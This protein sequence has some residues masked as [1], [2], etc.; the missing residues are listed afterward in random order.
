[1]SARTALRDAPPLEECGDL[2]IDDDASPTD[3]ETDS[4][5]FESG[6]QLLLVEDEAID[7]LQIRRLLQKTGMPSTLDE[8]ELVETAREAIAH[9]DFDCVLLDHNL[10]DGQ[11]TAVLELIKAIQADRA[12]AVVFVTGQR[13]QELAFHLLQSGAV[14][15][16]AKDGLTPAALKHAVEVALL[17]RKSQPR[18][19]SLPA[20]DPLTELPGLQPYEEALEGVIRASIRTMKPAMIFM[21]EVANLDDIAE[22][23]GQGAEN[24]LLKAVAGRLKTFLRSCDVAARTGGNR[25]ALI[26]QDLPGASVAGTL[27]ARIMSWLRQPYD[28]L[29]N[30]EPDIR[31]GVSICPHDGHSATALMRATEA[32]LATTSQTPAGSVRFYQAQLGRRMDRRRELTADLPSAIEKNQLQMRFQ[33]VIDCATGRMEAVAAAM[34]WQHPVHGPVFSDEFLPLAE[35]AGLIGPIGEWALDNCCDAMGVWATFQQQQLCCSIPVSHAELSGGYLTAITR[36]KAEAAGIMPSQIMFRFNTAVLAHNS[37]IVARE[38]KL[39][40]ESG[41]QVAVEDFGDPLLPAV[42]L[43]KAPGQWLSLSPALVQGLAPSGPPDDAQPWPMRHIAAM[44]KELGIRVVATGIGNNVQLEQARACGVGFVQ[45]DFI[46]PPLPVDDL[47]VW[48]RTVTR[49]GIWNR[50]GEEPQGAA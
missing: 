5:S 50:R 19:R 32:A 21:V 30:T 27:A 6:P 29:G 24:A 48:R 1:M 16:I 28:F 3:P 35:A 41:I 7:R 26:A 12:P 42:E 9:R 11:G 25:F 10:G 46:A 4:Q 40:Q 37:T 45:G 38:L 36:A 22:A 14:D 13:D 34:R 20:L 43:D 2:L 17:R 31:M 39:L 15:V 47:A 49:A 18:N 44:A 8:A 33:P 23:L